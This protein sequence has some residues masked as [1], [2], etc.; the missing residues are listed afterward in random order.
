MRWGKL[1][2]T[3]DSPHFPSTHSC[4]R[5]VRY[6]QQSNDEDD[7]GGGGTVAVWEFTA[8]TECHVRSREERP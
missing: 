4:S 5:I 1:H 2:C 3:A 8:A 7:G 6:T